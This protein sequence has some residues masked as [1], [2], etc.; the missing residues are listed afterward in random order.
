MPSGTDSKVAIVICSSV[1]TSACATPPLVSGDSGPVS[2]IDWVKKDSVPHHGRA[3]DQGV[4][5]LVDDEGMASR[6]AVVSATATTRSR[7]ASRS[8]WS[9]RWPV[10]QSTNSRYQQ[11]QKPSTPVKGSTRS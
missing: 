7:T 5:D 11:S 10:K 3:A 8:H 2:T 9:E 6:P 1:P 4:A